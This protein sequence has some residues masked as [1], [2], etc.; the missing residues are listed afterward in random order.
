[1]RFL[2]EID[3]LYMDGTFK[4]AARFFIQMFTIHGNMVSKMVIIYTIGFLFITRQKY[5]HVY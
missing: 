2:C 5:E 1:M 3:D 4:Y